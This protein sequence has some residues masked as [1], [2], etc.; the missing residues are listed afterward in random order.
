M[1]EDPPKN[2]L[3]TFLKVTGTILKNSLPTSVATVSFFVK[4][5]VSLHFVGSD[6][7]DMAALGFSFA[8]MDAFAVALV[9]CFVA[10]YGNINSQAYGA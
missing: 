3:K 4:D 6:K 5:M 9:F 7:E 1:S 2:D 8:W 10:G